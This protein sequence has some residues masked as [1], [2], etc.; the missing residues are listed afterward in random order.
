MNSSAILSPQKK[1]TKTH[2][3]TN[4]KKILPASENIQR[5]SVFYGRG[6]LNRGQAFRASHT[7]AQPPTLMPPPKELMKCRSEGRHLKLSFTRPQRLPT[8]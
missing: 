4:I 2:E 7:P 5:Q 6:Q 8:I 3:E 1:N